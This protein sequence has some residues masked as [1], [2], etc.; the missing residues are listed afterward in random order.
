[1]IFGLLQQVCMLAG[2]DLDLVKGNVRRKVEAV[3]AREETCQQ[4]SGI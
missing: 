2:L 1:M 3:L 4:E